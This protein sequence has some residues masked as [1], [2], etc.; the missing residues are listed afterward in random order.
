MPESEFQYGDYAL[1]QRQW[2]TGE[3]LDQQLDYWRQRLA[4]A[5]GILELPA[6]RPRPRVQTFA[7]AREKILLTE[8]LQQDIET[9]TQAQDV[10]LFMLVVATVTILLSRYTGQGDLMVGTP[11]AGRNRAELEDLIGLFVNTLVLRADLAGD[12]TFG[13]L[14]GRVRDLTLGAYA[15]QDL[16]FEKLVEEIQPERNLSQT[17]LFQVMT[18]VDNNPATPWRLE[19]LTLIPLRT[20]ARTAK[21]DLTFYYGVSKISIEYN[22]DLFDVT[23]VRRFLRHWQ[24]VLTAAVSDPRKRLSRFGILTPAERQQLAVEWNDTAV[25]RASQR[26]LPELFTAQVERTPDGVAV[27]FED[28]QLSYRELDRRVDSL[29]RHLCR[30]G[31]GPE[32][33][34]GVCAQRSPELVTALLAVHRAGGAYVPLDP[35]YPAE[36]L[37]VMIRTAA[38][39]VLLAQN[40]V[41]ERLPESDADRFDLNDTTWRTLPENRATAGKGNADSPAYVIFTSGSTGQPKGCTNSHRA[42]VNRLLWMQETY[43]LGPED[44]VLQKTPFSFDVSVWEFFWPLMTGACLVLARPG[45]HRDPV[46]LHRVVRERR[47]TTVHFVP[48]MLRSFLESPGLDAGTSLRWV[49]ASGEALPADLRD[50]P[51][52]LPRTVLHNLYG[53]TEAA[54]DVTFQ[55]CDVVSDNDVVAIGRPISNLRMHL[56]DATLRPVP[57]GVAGELFIAG[58]GLGRGYHARPGLTAERFIPNPEGR[59]AGERMYRTGD[60]ARFLPDGR[61]EFLGR[62][63]HQ[64]KIRGF[65]I[66]LGEIE[67]V[68]RRHPSVGEVVV[69]NREDASGTQTLAAYLTPHDQVPGGEGEWLRPL[70][71]FLEQRLPEYMVPAAF[72]ALDALPLTASGK[73][74]R[75]ALPAPGAESG[76]AELVVPETPLEEILAGIW[77]EVLG[78]ERV[79][80]RDDFFALGG[81]SLLA[82][83][84]ISRIRRHLG[85]EL[86]LH[87][88]FQVP[89]VAQLARR[90]EQATR[91]ELPAL[92]PVP[93]KGNLPLSFAQERLWFIDRMV[94]PGEPGAVAYNI[95]AAIRLHGSLNVSLLVASLNA[96]V[97]RHESLRTTFREIDGRP[98][99]VVAPSLEVV[100]PV[101]DLSALA[102]ERQETRARELAA[103]EAARPFDLRRG[104]L[105]RAL[106]LR[107]TPQE[108]VAVFTLHHIISDGWSQGLLVRE[109]SAWYAALAGGS[110]APLPELPIQY[111]D[112]AVWQRRWLAGEALDQELAWWRQELAASP[113]VLDLPTDR[114]RPPVQ[115]FRGRSEPVQLAPE[116]T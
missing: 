62:I 41:A 98:V 84:V 2:L 26:L 85:V 48:S 87:S 24:S 50:H 81:H 73:V 13:E 68:L 38:P 112:F 19:A 3:V 47:I 57:V 114:P 15:H 110:P 9:F 89:T 78:R 93:R 27:Q 74:D 70:R 33:R 8:S 105:V 54:V 7:G 40:A 106:L 44:R 32:V 100:A 36:R 17:P 111:A 66:E 79:G 115:S 53:P 25:P 49:I 31:V 69:V 18:T 51:A 104:P 22:R 90:V 10:T 97:R 16:P 56:L 88:F 63:D 46:Y 102:Q 96:I 77:A 28:Q 42:I 92:V 61:I 30:L 71:G 94:T 101:V 65:R 20:E 64:V 43:Q 34:V 37:G 21:F 35:D 45:G 83:R 86:P 12:P 82:T 107:L 29:S 72:T 4:G 11:I 39:A 52:K 91:T 60:L 14:L 55:P 75:N 95:P 109:L 116:L 99:Q 103:V 1:W 6:D 59:E 23:T 80:T 58:M 113:Q 67:A 5:S 108:H 76:E